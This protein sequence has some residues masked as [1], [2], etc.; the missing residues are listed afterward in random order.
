MSNLARLLVDVVVVLDAFNLDLPFAES[1]VEAEVEFFKLSFDLFKI[2]VALGVFPFLITGFVSSL[3]V[4]FFCS[5]DLSFGIFSR[6]VDVAVLSGNNLDAVV[7]VDVEVLGFERR[8]ELCEELVK[9]NG[10]KDD[11]VRDEDTETGL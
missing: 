2:V 7:F 9:A 4:S 10:I 11:A 1:E 6:A 5:F 3:V 8:N